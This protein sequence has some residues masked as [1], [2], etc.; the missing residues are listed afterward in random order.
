MK[1]KQN[2]NISQEKT[3]PENNTIVRPHLGKNKG[4]SVYRVAPKTASR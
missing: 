4:F 3:E 2:V 1:A